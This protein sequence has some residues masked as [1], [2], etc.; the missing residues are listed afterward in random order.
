MVSLVV[1]SL[2]TCLTI[3]WEDETQGLLSMCWNHQSDYTLII[4]DPNSS[5]GIPGS[6][7]LEVPTIYKAYIRPKFQGI[8]LENMPLYSTIPPFQD[9][10]IPIEQC[11]TLRRPELGHSLMQQTTLFLKN[12]KDVPWCTSRQSNMAIENSHLWMFMDYF[13]IKSF[14]CRAISQPCLITGGC[15]AMAD[16]EI[17]IKDMEVSENRRNYGKILGIHRKIHYEWKFQ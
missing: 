16:R 3:K 8:S 10:E 2:P 15:Q 5:M 9:P 1:S 14:I 11:L 6:D 12:F 17:P 13:P 7:S 4:S